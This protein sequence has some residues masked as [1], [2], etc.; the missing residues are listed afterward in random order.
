MASVWKGW[1]APDGEVMQTFAILTTTAN[2]TMSALHERMPVILEPQDWPR[3]LGEADGDD[4]LDAAG[5]RR[6]VASLAGEPCGQ[7]G[8]QQPRRVARPD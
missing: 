8:A 7:Q 3:W 4:G 1:R 6:H 5:A 2:T